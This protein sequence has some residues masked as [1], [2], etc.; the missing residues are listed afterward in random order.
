MLWPSLKPSGEI[1]GDGHELALLSAT[2]ET[3]ANEPSV[4]D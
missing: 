3:M 2:L 4:A 1:L